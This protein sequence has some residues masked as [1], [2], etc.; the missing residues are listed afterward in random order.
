MQDGCGNTVRFS[1]R[2]FELCRWRNPVTPLV[3][4]YGANC[5]PYPG[6]SIRWATEDER[7]L[8]SLRL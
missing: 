5:R 2:G 7:L 3:A 8:Q 6:K 1:G 4:R